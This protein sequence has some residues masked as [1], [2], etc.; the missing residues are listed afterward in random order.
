M[1]PEVTVDSKPEGLPMATA[2]WPTTRFWSELNLAAGR[3]SRPTFTTAMSVRGSL[4]TTCPRS[5]VPSA[6]ATFTSFAS[7]ITWLFVMMYPSLRKITPLPIPSSLWLPNGVVWVAFTFTCTTLG[8][9]WA[10]TLATGSSSGIC[11]EACAGTWARLFS[12]FPDF[13]E[14]PAART[15][16]SAAATIRRE[17]ALSFGFNFVETSCRRQRRASYIT[18]SIRRGRPTVSVVSLRRGDGGQ[19]RGPAGSRPRGGGPP[20]YLLEGGY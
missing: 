6:K 20:L 13:S 16:A 14:Q 10:A 11:G 2:S 12:R 5:V 19:K 9:T 3:L 1:T 18:E 15:V 8:L 17:H 7:W 4:A